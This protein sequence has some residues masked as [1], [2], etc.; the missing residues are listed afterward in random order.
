MKRLLMVAVCLSALAL[1]QTTINGGRTITG[2]LDASSAT[3]TKPV[4]T[5]TSAPATCAV[6]ELFYDTDEVAGL[7]LYTCTA[8]NIWTRT[9]YA[10]GTAAPVTCTLGQVFFDTDAAAGSN[11]MLCTAT[12]TWTAVSGGG[13]TPTD[14]QYVALAANGTLTNERVLTA[15]QGI[16]ITDA[17]AGNAVTVA[18]VGIMRP[19]LRLWGISYSMGSGTNVSSMGDVFSAQ[20]TPSLSTASDA[21]NGATV[22][23][24]TGATTDSDAG[25]YGN[26]KWRTGRSLYYSWRGYIGEKTAVRTWIGFS[27]AGSR[28]TQ[29]A[30][31]DPAGKM[32]MFRF[33]SNASDTYWQCVTKD[34]SATVTSSNVAP[35]TSAPQLLEIE[36]TALS[37]IFKIDGTTVCTHTTNLPPSGTNMAGWMMS[38]TLE[39]AAKNIHYGHYY[40]EAD[41]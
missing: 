19:S 12:D 37:W 17:G 38:R 35:S 8:A 1:G 36:E 39:S 14:A 10:Q 22:K 28:A 33:S 27:N 26:S 6:G 29:M 31:D 13:G 11:L 21:N 40:T 41:R 5:G 34:G 23:Y 32:A 24:T 4:K 2:P 7:G 25:F 18:G 3:V 30:G 20:G 9:P 15:G 16:T